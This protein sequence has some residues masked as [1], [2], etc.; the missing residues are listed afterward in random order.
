MSLDPHDAALWALIA[1]SLV[2][3]GALLTPGTVGVDERGAVLAGIVAVLAAIGLRSRRR[4]DG[5]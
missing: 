4:K 5:E 2:L 3:V 1:I